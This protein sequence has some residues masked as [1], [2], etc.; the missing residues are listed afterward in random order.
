M[1]LEQRGQTELLSLPAK[2]V[3][4]YVVSKGTKHEGN[5]RGGIF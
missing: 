2:S 3:E 5:I 4:I 1:V